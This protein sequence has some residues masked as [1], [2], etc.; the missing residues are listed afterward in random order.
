MQLGKGL[1][2]FPIGENLRQGL[3]RLVDVEVAGDGQLSLSAQEL[4]IQL[5]DLVAGNGLDPHNLLLDRGKVPRIVLVVRI[6]PPPYRT[7][8]QRGRI[9]ELFFERRRLLTLE[10]LEL[11]FR[12]AWFPKHLPQKFE[13]RRQV[14]ALGLDH[15]RRLAGI[16]RGI[17]LGPLLVEDI[18]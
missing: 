10:D 14:G 4:V 15:K 2:R 18:L 9:I 5:F 7:K 11:F 12:Q 1:R 16:D 3:H 6:E 17:Q 8:R 13:H